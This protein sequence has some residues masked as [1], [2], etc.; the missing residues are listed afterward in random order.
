VGKQPQSRR[1]LQTGITL[2]ERLVMPYEQAR[3]HYEIGRH[4]ENTIERE[5]HL[6]KANDMYTE[7]G[8]SAKFTL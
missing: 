3:I 2:A 5:V 4:G 6:Q 1:S 8:V 7:L